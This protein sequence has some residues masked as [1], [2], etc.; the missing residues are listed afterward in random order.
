MKSA[1][2]PEILEKQDLSKFGSLSMTWKHFS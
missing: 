1:E 2:F